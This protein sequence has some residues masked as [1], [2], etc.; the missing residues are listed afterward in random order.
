MFALNAITPTTKER[1]T[2]TPRRRLID[3]PLAVGSERLHHSARPLDAPVRRLF[4]SR[5]RYDFSRVRIYTDEAAATSANAIHA[6]A[7]TLAT[8]SSSA[9]VATIRRRA[10]VVDC[11]RTS[12]LMSYSRGAPL[13]HKGLRVE[14]QSSR[15]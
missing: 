12:F 13:L 2:T 8:T 11:W 5:F 14:K 9:G 10:Q 4:E 1:S 6:S 3:A 15:P 7:Y